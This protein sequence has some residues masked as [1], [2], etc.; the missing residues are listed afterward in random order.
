MAL[1]WAWHRPEPFPEVPFDDKFDLA[2]LDLTMAG[3]VL[4]Y[5]GNGGVPGEGH[6]DILRTCVLELRAAVVLPGRSAEYREGRTVFQRL[7][8]MAELILADAS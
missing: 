8:T 5:L 4:T 3:C 1:L 2:Y 6:L 7:L